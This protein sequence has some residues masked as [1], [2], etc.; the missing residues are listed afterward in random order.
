MWYGTRLNH[1]MLF[2][3]ALSYP[4][5]QKAIASTMETGEIS[6]GGVFQASPGFQNSTDLTTAFYASL[7]SLKEGET[8]SYEGEPMSFFAYPVFDSHTKVKKEVVAI[9]GVV[10]NW[11]SYFRGVVPPGS[12]HVVLVL[13]NAC[14]GEFSYL[15][16]N[17]EVIYLGEGD[18]HNSKYDHLERSAELNSLYVQN[19]PDHALHLDEL[20]CPFKLRVYPT[21]E[22]EEDNSTNIPFITTL[23]VGLVFVFTAL[24]FW[25]FNILVEKRQQIVLNQAKQSTAVVSAFLPEAVQ[26]RLLG[27]SG[28]SDNGGYSSPMKRLKTFLAE[29]EDQ[30]NKK[31]IADLFPFTTVL[32][33]D[34]A[35]FTAWAST[36]EPAQVFVLLQT[37]YQAFD[38][39]AKK[40]KV[41]KVET[42]GDSYVAVT[43]LPNE[44]PRHAVLMARFA[45]ECLEKFRK[46]H[47]AHYN[48]L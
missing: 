34:I 3:A 13:E 18:L 43:G 14:D 20:S 41:F 1:G 8:V 33:A 23:A 24:V 28:D 42:I 26:E 2:C 11:E 9:L 15:V 22:M 30:G 36:R 4:P 45:W 47:S 7:K 5:Y 35:G 38:A 46:Y 48:V 44:Q 16:D 6:L 29:G 39:L 17:N 10:V 19:K 27:S 37:V 12:S 32:F 25:I 21:S 31:P 40:H